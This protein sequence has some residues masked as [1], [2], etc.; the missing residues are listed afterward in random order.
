[1]DLVV[2]CVCVS[3]QSLQCPVPMLLLA[4]FVVSANGVVRM[5]WTRVERNRCAPDQFVCW[6][7]W[8]RTCGDVI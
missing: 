4:A 6:R 7:T 8:R 2:L 3:C 1:M 5:C